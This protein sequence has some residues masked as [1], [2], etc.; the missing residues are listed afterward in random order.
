MVVRLGMVGSSPGNGHPYSFAAIFN[1]YHTKS[2]RASGWN[3]IADYLD[4]R[5]E[6]D[7]GIDGFAVTHVWSPIDG[8]SERVCKAARIPAAVGDLGELISEVDG[9]IIARD[10]PE[11]HI[12]LAQPFLD[13]GL[14]VFI[15]KPLTVSPGE[16]DYFRPFLSSGQVFSCSSMRYAAEL[17]PL[18]STE[19]ALAV[20][21]AG[22]KDWRRYGVHLVEG[23][24]AHLSVGKPLSITRH[25]A[26]HESFTVETEAGVVLHFDL[27][28]EATVGFDF[29]CVTSGGAVSARVS[30]NFSM[31]R[32]MLEAFCK[33]IATGRPAI[34][35]ESTCQVIEVVIAGHEC[36]QGDS[37]RLG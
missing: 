3:V 25:H 27:C 33:Q 20:Y 34:A 26:R 22:P 28:G 6:K 30:D 16:L 19:P 15:D 1:G 17:Q 7:F 36:A 14:P 13:A 35:P 11:S 10:D 4:R 8:E 31:F 21:C 24:L 23:A 9:V 12:G 5:A 29:H 37:I 32:K 2:L 18:T